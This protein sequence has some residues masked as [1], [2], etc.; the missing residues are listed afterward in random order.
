M[1]TAPAAA[2]GLAL[3]LPE[4]TEADHHGRPSFR[5]AGRIIATVP[6]GEALHVMVD[7][8]VAH[9]A[10]AARP[11][12]VELLWWGRRLSRV[13]IRLAAASE[14]LVA[15][16]LEAAWRRRAPARLRREASG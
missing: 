11:D 15:D 13:R 10:A 1:T 9:A 3:A 5:V 16:L 8:D 14:E 12:A 7:D 2:R 6:D 4:V